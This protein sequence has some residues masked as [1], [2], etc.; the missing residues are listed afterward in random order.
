[1][2]TH[3]AQGFDGT[4]Q[5]VSRFVPSTDDENIKPYE[6]SHER[7]EL[8]FTGSNDPAARRILENLAIESPIVEALRSN[9]A[10]TFTALENRP[11]IVPGSLSVSAA[12]TWVECP[13]RFYYQYALRLQRESSTEAQRGTAMHDVLARFHSEFA[14][15]D[16]DSVSALPRWRQRLRELRETVWSESNFEPD[17][18]RDATASLAD[19]QLERY[20]E[21]LAAEAQIRPF[22]VVATE[23]NIEVAFSSG[24]LRGRIDRIDRL[25]DGS[26][27]VRDYKTGKR[28]TTF[29]R[30][31]QKSFKDGAPGPGAFDPSLRPQ[32]AL[33]RNG[34]EAMIGAPVSTLEFIYLKGGSDEVA[35][36][37]DSTTISEANRPMLDAFN[38]IVEREFVSGFAVG[39]EV[40]ITS[41]EAACRFCEFGIRRLCPGADA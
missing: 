21:A 37:R 36:S 7:F 14:T 39:A 18:V 8:Q 34:V 2:I 19:R 5:R 24:T 16:R 27:I 20:A 4:P 17:A 30:A 1:L 3:A 9:G 6:R 28:R 10:E 11:V 35:I 23:R 31:L 22:T 26:L 13:R 12:S 15:F 29:L 38:E 41:D 40:P 25:A 33:Y 32:L